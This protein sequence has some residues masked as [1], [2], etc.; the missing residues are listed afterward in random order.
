M[1]FF[2]IIISKIFFR[3]YSRI[4]SLY[5][6]QYHNYKDISSSVKFCPEFPGIVILINPN[7]IFIDE[8]SVLNK[9]THI[10]PG[11][12]LVKIGRYCHIGQRLTIYGFNHNFERP[13]SIPYDEVKISKDVIIKDFVWIGAN[14][15]ILPGVSIGEGAIVGAGSVVTKDI[16]DFS[17]AAGNP[18]RVIKTRNSEYFNE[19]RSKNK[20]F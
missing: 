17:I 13:K 7:R 15:T 6:S 20:F 12:A 18:A 16:P 4:C 5:N 9:N 10:N 2:K 19:L 1:P 8:N 14:V 3:I 11:N